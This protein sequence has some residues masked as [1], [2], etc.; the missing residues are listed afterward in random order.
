MMGSGKK[1]NKKKT[2]FT[3]PFILDVVTIGGGHNNQRN[4]IDIG[5]HCIKHQHQ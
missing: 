1:Q 3:F 5:N 4:Y 2:A